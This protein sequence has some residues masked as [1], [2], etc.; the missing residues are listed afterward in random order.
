VSV[1]APIALLE[2]AGDLVAL[3]CDDGNIRIVDARPPLFENTQSLGGGRLLRTLRCFS[4]N[5][6]PRSPRDLAFGQPLHRTL[7]AVCANG[8]LRVWDLATAALIDHASFRSEATSVAASPTGEF[9]A[10]THVDDSAVSLWTDKAAYTRVDAKPLAIDAPPKHLAPQ[11]FINEE[12]D[13]ESSTSSAN[14]ENTQEENASFRLRA[15]GENTTLLSPSVAVDCASRSVVKLSGQPRGRA[16]TLHALEAIS[17]R[18]RPVEPPKKPENA[19]F[20]LPSSMPTFVEEQVSLP[21]DLEEDNH[22]TPNSKRRRIE[23]FEGAHRCRLATVALGTET[24]PV[25]EYL[26]SLSPPAVDADILLLCRGFDDEPGIDN[27][28]ALLKHMLNALNSRHDFEAVQAYLHR[29]LQHHAPVLFASSRLDNLLCEIKQAQ[30]RATNRI[31]QLFNETN[32]LVD[33]LLARP[34]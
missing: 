4:D 20:F 32:C 15:L 8:S 5:E 34:N 17:E 28:A 1:G 6:P 13:S 21:Q 16:E 2:R 23:S 14:S 10:T 29:I 18:N 27:L 30:T 33:F 24:G 19:P 25:L 11:T 9:L 26:N 22:E 3:A 12:N 7:Y 31:R